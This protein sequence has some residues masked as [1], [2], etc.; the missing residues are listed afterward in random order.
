MRIDPTNP[1]PPVVK[2]RI[3]P[4][5]IP[6]HVPRDRVRSAGLTYGKEFL[7]D[8]HGFMAKMHETMPPIWYDVGPFG[9]AWA[10]IKHED[11]LF[12][13]RNSEIFTIEDATPFPRDPND[14]YYF[15]PIEVDPPDHRWYRMI[16][17]PVFSP[18]GVLKLEGQI[19]ALAN[20]LID[21]VIAKGGCEFDVAFGRPLPVLVFLDLMGL[22]REKCDTFV[23]W[24]M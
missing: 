9:N 5:Q 8:P 16:L 18:Q 23:S 24:A 20:E 21:D 15:L 13:L 6:D 4:D 7:A 14:Y 10:M 3:G 11:A 12:A 22:P 17:E 19:R 1:T 2:R